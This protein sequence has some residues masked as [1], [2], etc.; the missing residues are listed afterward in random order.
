MKRSVVDEKP[1]VSVKRIDKYLHGFNNIKIFVSY[2][3]HLKNLI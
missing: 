1:H 3:D 2:Y